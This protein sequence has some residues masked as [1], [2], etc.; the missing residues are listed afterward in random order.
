LQLTEIQFNKLQGAKSLHRNITQHTNI[1]HD[2]I[3]SCE[4]VIGNRPSNNL[5]YPTCCINSCVVFVYKEIENNTIKT[6]NVQ[7]YIGCQL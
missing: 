1:V 4:P 7:I 2:W 3:W 6:V 5:R